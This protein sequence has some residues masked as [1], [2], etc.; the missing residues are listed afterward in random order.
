MARK[1]QRGANTQLK[2]ATESPDA[3]SEVHSVTSKSAPTVTSTRQPVHARFASETGGEL[4][5]QEANSEHIEANLKEMK[6]K[7]GQSSISSDFALRDKPVLESLPRKGGKGINSYL[8][9]V[10]NYR[11]P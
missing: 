6:G 9:F 10:D 7:K 4:E 3:A 11:Y 5:Q 2:Q 1:A 8:N